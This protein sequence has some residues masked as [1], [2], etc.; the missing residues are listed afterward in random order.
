MFRVGDFQKAH[1]DI[2]GDLGKPVVLR[3]NTGTGFRDYSGAIGWVRQYNEDELVPG[4][5]IKT[6]D[7]RMVILKES[8][9]SQVTRLQMGDRVQIDGDDYAVIVWDV[10][11]RTAGNTVFAVEAAVRG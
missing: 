7:L 3:V 8:I 2:L 6:G 10:Q 11:S 9:P 4:G 5:T 1:R